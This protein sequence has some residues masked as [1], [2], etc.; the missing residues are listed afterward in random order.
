MVTNITSLSRNGLLDWLVQRV[1]AVIIGVYMVGVLGFLI[2]QPDMD[3]ATWSGFMG[4]APMQIANTLLLFSVAVHTWS[5][6][7]S[8][9][10]DYLTSLTFGKAATSVRLMTQVVIVL[11]LLVYVLWGLTMIW[12]GA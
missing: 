9:T 7:W 10:T 12:G 3:F 5:G 6:T 1:S 2:F 8:V 4:S 11:L